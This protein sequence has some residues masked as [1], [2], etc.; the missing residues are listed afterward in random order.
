MDVI[1]RERE[2]MLL[3]FDSLFRSF[4]LARDDLYDLLM[5]RTQ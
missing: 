2:G 5:T 3:K 4:I 1:D